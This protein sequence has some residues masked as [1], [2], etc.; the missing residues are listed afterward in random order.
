MECASGGGGETDV[1]ELSRLLSSLLA[2]IV[3]PVKDGIQ[4]FQY[5]WTSPFAGVTTC[6]GTCEG[7]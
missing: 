2:L 5:L 6:D 4:D 7:Q 1:V 3:I